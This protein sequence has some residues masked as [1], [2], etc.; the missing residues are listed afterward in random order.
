MSAR[1]ATKENVEKAVLALSSRGEAITVDSVIRETGGGSKSTVAPILRQ[2]QSTIAGMKSPTADVPASVKSAVNKAML[3]IWSAAEEEA[4][5]TFEE[6]QS[7]YESFLN[8]QSE[9]LLAASAKVAS[10]QEQN[11]ALNVE[12]DAWL[13]REA[14]LASELQASDE[15]S[16]MLLERNLS[17]E[18]QLATTQARLEQFGGLGGQDAMLA[19]MTRLATQLDQV[20]K[21][22]GEQGGLS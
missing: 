4:R 8:G 7:R 13:V 16:R 11:D 22:A 1:L 20:S 14:K 9:E 19:L 12:R 5:H 21:P 6:I 3:S 2:L 15:R 17:L 18:G 10:L